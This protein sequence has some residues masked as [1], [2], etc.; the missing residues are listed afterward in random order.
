MVRRGL[1]E[2]CVLDEF[3]AY[4]GVFVLSLGFEAMLVAQREE[5]GV[6]EA[7]AHGVQAHEA[8][9]LD[10]LE[11]LLDWLPGSLLENTGEVRTLNGLLV[12]YLGHIPQTGDSFAVGDVTFYIIDADQTVV[13]KVR[14]TKRGRDV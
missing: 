8:N 14:I 11:S 9:G 7:D 12:N 2:V 13:R 10:H 3:G 6:G 1:R 4:A 5:G